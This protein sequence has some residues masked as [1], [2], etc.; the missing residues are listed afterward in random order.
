MEN[1]GT[2]R[3]SMTSP[4]DEPVPGSG[5]F[6]LFNATAWALIVL[7]PAFLWTIKL[8]YSLHR[9]VPT[10]NLKVPVILILMTPVIFQACNLTTLYTNP[11]T[12]SLFVNLGCKV[13]LGFI[14]FAFYYLLRE[15]VYFEQLLKGPDITNSDPYF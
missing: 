11:D 1:S 13:Y 4:G 7:V 6:T 10:R 14:F 5:F 2:T 15:V 3:G 9:T 8:V 12:G